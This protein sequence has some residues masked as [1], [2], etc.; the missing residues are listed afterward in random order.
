MIEHGDA[1][2]IA[3]LAQ[4]RREL[5]VGPR[6]GRIARGVVVA[7]DDGGRRLTDERPK[8]VARMNLHAGERAARQAV[9]ALHA[10]ADVEAQRPELLDRQRGQPAAQVR[11]DLGR[12]GHPLSA[13]RTGGDR[14][15]P[16]LQRRRDQGGAHRADAGEAGQLDGRG[17]QKPGGALD[18]AQ[19]RGR[20]LQRARPASARS[21]HHGQEL[22]VG[23]LLGAARRQ[24]LAGTGVRFHGRDQRHAPQPSQRSCHGRAKIRARNPSSEYC[25]GLPRRAC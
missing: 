3:H 4:P 11:P 12:A 23:E 15:P 6:G 17:A 7:E 5:D 8:D 16:E 2:Q 19:N 14:A 18:A 21:E 9:L 24:P 1:A 10:V 20:H 25:F 13:R 22:T